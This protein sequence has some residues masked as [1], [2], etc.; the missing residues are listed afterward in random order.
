MS[1]AID[2]VD[3]RAWIACVLKVDE[4]DFCVLDYVMQ[5]GRHPRVGALYSAHDSKRMQDVRLWLGGRIPLTGMGVESACDSS[6]KQ[7]EVI[8][9]HAFHFD[10]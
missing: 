6:F 10:A 8:A 7:V 9:V 5:Y 1:E 2:G 3:D 4:G